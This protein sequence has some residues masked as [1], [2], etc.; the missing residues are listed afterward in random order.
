[1][2]PRKK[3]V[4]KN[5]S[6]SRE[7]K[8]KFLKPRRGLFFTLI[9]NLFIWGGTLFAGLFVWFT[10]D[11]PDVT[12]M[13][14][15][16]RKPG[17]TLLARDN[18]VL[19]TYG[20]LYGRFVTLKDLPDHVPKA[21]MAIED[22]RFYNHFGVDPWGILRAV[23]NNW[24]SGGV[25]QGGSTLTQQLAKNFLL[26]EGLYTYQDKSLRRKI[27]EVILAFWL[28]TKFSKDQ[29]LTLYL[30]RV[31]LGAGVYG[32]DAAAHKYFGKSA[33]NLTLYEAAVI[34]GLLKAP[35]KYSPQAHP[36]EAH[37]R[38]KVV[39]SAMAEAGMIDAALR[40]RYEIPPPDLY[41]A[42]Q[43]AS[44]GRYFAD[45]IFENLEI[46]LGGLNQDVIVK[47]T[48]DIRLQ[49]L[50]E[51]SLKT[52]VEK[53]GR[54]KNVSQAALVSITP[55]GAVRA[56]V[57]GVDY[58]HS[59]FNRATQAKR[60]P[61]SAFKLFIYLTVLQKGLNAQTQVSDLPIRLGKWQPKNYSWIPRGEVSLQDSFAYSIN[62]TT[63]RLAHQAG[64][65]ALAKMAFK[66]GLR[67]PQPCDL[68]IALGSGEATLLEV[69]AAYGVVANHGYGVE[70]Y[71]IE[72]IRDSEG[73]IL[74]RKKR[75][76]ALQKIT[77]EQ[78]G[79]MTKLLQ[80]SF[81]YGTGKRA[82]IGRPCAGKTG[83][84]QNH[85]D[86]WVIGFTPDLITGVWMGNDDNSPM[87]RVTGGTLPADLWRDYMKAAHTGLPEKNF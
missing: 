29:I 74:Y 57:G 41:R 73:K 54:E 44:T 79:E 86:A 71:G 65:D 69:T 40:A 64:R 20:D 22:R 34:A 9:L 58:V 61:G 84:S 77:E 13:M 7:A 51:E 2:A 56:L 39:L 52:V 80:A 37:A 11:L 25:R 6:Q 68:T 46:L 19:A 23:V 1:M 85:K 14:T 50:A 81:S 72:E 67:S 24:R 49:N 43:K 26:S 38:A 75:E 48:L 82:H 33:R 21:L 53:Q 87:K 32:I 18:S 12:R 42:R 3:K 16:T 66:L 15:A 35:T 10:Y 17:V 8:K 47:T 28:E 60:Q 36:E 31:Y 30:N 5:K 62:T 27:Q 70:P 63:V 59:Q 83:T 76:S 4:F 45:W 78:A 55:R